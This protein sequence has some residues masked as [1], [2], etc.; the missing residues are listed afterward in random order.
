[1]EDEKCSTG[2]ESQDSFELK[3]KM[4][5]LHPQ[6][7]TNSVLRFNFVWFFFRQFGLFWS[8]LDIKFG[9]C[10]QLLGEKLYV[11]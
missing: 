9:I 6:A 10:G 11:E 8:D 2:W 1:M 7:F 4:A 5:N 3:M